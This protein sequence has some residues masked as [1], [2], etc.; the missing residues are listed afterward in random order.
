[1][2]PV[3]SLPPG[4]GC[5]KIEEHLEE[6]D[7]CSYVQM[8]SQKLYD[9]GFDSSPLSLAS[10]T[11]DGAS[12]YSPTTTLCD[13]GCGTTTA[14]GQPVACCPSPGSVGHPELCRRPCMYFQAGHCENGNACNFCHLEHPDKLAKLD[15]KQRMLLQSLGVAEFV[16]FVLQFVLERLQQANLVDEG[17][18][19]VK[20]LR[21]VAGVQPCIADRDARNLR[22]T[23]ARMNLSN[24]M[25]V[26]IHK[27]SNSEEGAHMTSRIDEITA[28]LDQLREQV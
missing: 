16:A 27:T 10:T 14:F 9:S 18:E 13:Q 28:A 15:K 23:F 20:L 25:G 5:S 3:K 26:L 19:L 12:P 8:L 2:R 6:A 22:K 11:C 4:L 7:R 1:M 17:H 24:L 21:S